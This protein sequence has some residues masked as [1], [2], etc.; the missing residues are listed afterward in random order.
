MM[1]TAAAANELKSNIGHD[2]NLAF[3]LADYAAEQEAEDVDA[4]TTEQRQALNA[5]MA[6]WF[7]G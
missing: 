3:E 6:E 7:N 2:L 5:S 4:M 1:N